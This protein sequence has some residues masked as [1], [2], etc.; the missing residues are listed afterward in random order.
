MPTPISHLI[1]SVPS[2]FIHIFG[3]AQTATKSGINSG[4]TDSD[5]GEPPS[6]EYEQFD[7]SPLRAT[8][9]R[10]R[11]ETVSNLPIAVIRSPTCAVS[12]EGDSGRTRTCLKEHQTGP[13]APRSACYRSRAQLDGL[14]IPGRRRG[15]AQRWLNLAPLAEASGTSGSLHTSL[16]SMIL[17]TGWSGRFGSNGSGGISSRLRSG[18]PFRLKAV[19]QSSSVRY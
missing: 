4:P 2:H 15:T 14:W 3:H 18:I 17:S 8:I 13:V 9:R 12:R 10:Y 5:Q 19:T 7:R 6:I 11:V 1:T 16:S